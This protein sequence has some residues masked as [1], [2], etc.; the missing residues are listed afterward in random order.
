MEAG[1]LNATYQTTILPVAVTDG[2]YARRAG[3]AGGRVHVRRGRVCASEL[4]RLRQGGHQLKWYMDDPGRQL[5]MP[6]LLSKR[7][8]LLTACFVLTLS[9]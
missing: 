9:F 7:R 3:R 8:P 6:V 2:G 4:L 1:V 5:P